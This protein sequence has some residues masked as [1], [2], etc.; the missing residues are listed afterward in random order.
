MI[1]EW[2]AR[3]TLCSQA[4]ERYKDHEEF[5]RFAGIP[6]LEGA[7]RVCHGLEL[8]AAVV[9]D[10]LLVPYFYGKPG[11][12]SKAVAEA[13]WELSVTVTPVATALNGILPKGTIAVVQGPCIFGLELNRYTV[14]LGPAELLSLI[15]EYISSPIFAPF[16][17]FLIVADTDY[18]ELEAAGRHYGVSAYVSCIADAPSPAYILL[19]EVHRELGDLLTRALGAAPYRGESALQ[20]VNARIAVKKEG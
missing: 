6:R 14:F 2:L 15:R 5:F 11:R 12:I 20:L 7:Y 3:G 1:C 19:C 13:L 4:Y 18:E 17:D 10:E 8:A 16:A 9:V